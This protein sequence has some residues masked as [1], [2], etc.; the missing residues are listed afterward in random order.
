MLSVYP[1]QG[2]L[3]HHLCMDNRILQQLC[4]S[5]G[6]MEVSAGAI[7]VH[8]LDAVPDEVLWVYITK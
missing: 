2:L 6:Q 8:V 4:S 5:L 3:R 1:H 7:L